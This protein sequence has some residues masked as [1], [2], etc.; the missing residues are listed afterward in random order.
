VTEILMMAA[1]GSIN[2]GLV[3]FLETDVS[4]RADALIQRITRF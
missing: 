1:V 4:E 3:A 2:L